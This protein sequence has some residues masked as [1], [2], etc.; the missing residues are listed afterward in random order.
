MQRFEKNNQNGSTLIITLIFL[1]VL[2][3]LAVSDSQDVIVNNK[4][5]SAMQQDFLVFARAES[6]MQQ[7]VFA[8]QGI[9]FELPDSP[10]TL[11]TTAKQ[12][13][14]DRCGNQTITI[15]SIAQDNHD[16]VVLNSLDIFAKVPKRKKCKKI[17]AHQVVWWK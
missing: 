15:Q 11:H 2:T 14:I 6:G 1:F 13:K 3:L 5:Q 12:I 4:M 7:M 16:K 10:I 17:P 8:L 9:S